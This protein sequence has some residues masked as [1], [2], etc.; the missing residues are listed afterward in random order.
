MSTLGNV[1]V[2]GAMM[3]LQK[4]L[5]EVA[6]KTSGEQL[7]ALRKRIEEIRSAA[8]GGWY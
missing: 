7:E 1:A 6:S 3:E 8:E 2:E 5:E 4:L